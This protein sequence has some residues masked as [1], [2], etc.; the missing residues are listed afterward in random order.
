MFAEINL[1]GPVDAKRVRSA[2]ADGFFLVPHTISES[3]LDE[4][5]GMLEE[6][7]RLPAEQKTECRVPG[8]HGQSGY[9]PPLVETAELSQAPDWK[10]LFHWGVALPEHHPLH[11]DYPHRYPAPLMPDHV[12]PGIGKALGELHTQ[13][14]DF[15]IQVTSVLGQALGVAPEYFAEMLEDGPVT[16]RA[17]WYP[18]MESA[19]SQGHVWAVEHKDFDLIT[20]LPRATAP[21]LEVRDVE[22]QWHR[23]SAP[24]GYAVVNVGMVLERLTGGLARAA[25][26][27]VVADPEQVGPRLSI[28]QFCHPTPWT[29]LTPLEIPGV[30]DR[31]Q[32]FPT[33]TADALFR[34]TM[35][36]INRF[37]T[38]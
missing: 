12:V 9:V 24:Q 31:P 34:R 16:N 6:F 17:A 33:L 26:H 1:E 8:S 38:E 5:Y 23:L 4:A 37:D 21:G 19:P 36:R 28:V 22:G 32:R 3:L 27:R 10:E 13:M 35:Y 25:V 7:F 14:K 18:P 11:A 20:A 30:E 15:Q 29:V 2:L